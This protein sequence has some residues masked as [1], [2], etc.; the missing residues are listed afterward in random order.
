MNFRRGKKLSKGGGGEAGEEGRLL[1]KKWKTFRGP[2]NYLRTLRDS[3]Y[4]I[5]L[6]KDFI[7]YCPKLNILFIFLFEMQ[8]RD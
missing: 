3:K 5:T 2:R 4:R 6:G 8:Q 1:A 7:Y